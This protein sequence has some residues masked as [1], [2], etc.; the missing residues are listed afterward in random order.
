MPISIEHARRITDISTQ[1]VDTRNVR[2]ETASHASALK[3]AQSQNDN[4]Y[5]GREKGRRGYNQGM[6]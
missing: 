5:K 1:T 3:V 4:N 6:V 2:G